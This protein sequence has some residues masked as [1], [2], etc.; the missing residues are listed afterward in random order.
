MIKP[1]QTAY[2]GCLFRSRLEARWAVFFDTIG[3]RWEYEAQGYELPHRLT[4]ADGTIRYLPD[5]WL[6]EVGAHVEVKGSLT[7][8]EMLRLL[9]CAAAL[10][11]PL[12]GCGE[13]PSLIICGQLPR[14][15]ENRHP[16]WTHM[17]KGDLLAAPFPYGMAGRQCENWP[18]LARDVGGAVD[19][20]CAE[21]PEHIRSALLNGIPC[22]V[23]GFSLFDAAYT[24]ARSARFE[25]GET[26]Q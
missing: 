12:G 26:P 5:F 6:P 19:D 2:A 9:D 10:S 4:L 24:R 3:T 16:V 11:A 25:H 18:V 20:V 7:D 14:P 17:H 1:I 8:D 22:R 21:A 13:G 15:G 23:A